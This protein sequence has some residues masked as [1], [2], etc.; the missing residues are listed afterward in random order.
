MNLG[1]PISVPFADLGSVNAPYRDELIQAF[2]KNLDSGWYI[3]G[4]QLKQF[5]S[6]F[7]AYVGVRDCVGVANGLDALSLVIRGWKEMG[8]LHEGDNVLVPANTYIA[9]ILA[10]TENNLVP[11][12]VEP[13]PVTFNI[14]PELLEKALNSKVR[15]VLAVHLY[16]QTANMSKIK[17]FSRDNGLI[18][19]EDAAQAHG[20]GHE[21]A[22]AGALGDASGFSFY[23]GKN[24]GALGDAGAITTN[25]EELTR[26]L[27]ALRNYGSE[28]KYHNQFRGVNSRLDEVQAAFLRVKL[29]YLNSENEKRRA[30]SS[31]YSKHIQNQLISLPRVPSEKLEH[32]WHAFVIRCSNRALL[33]AHLEGLGIQTLVHYP[34]PPHKQPAYSQL[35]WANVS[36]PIT[37]QIHREVLSL[38]ISPTMSHIEVDS[39]VKAVNSFGT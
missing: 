20:A 32:V 30:I 8:L 10:I 18:V 4:E 25:D 2:T 27:R 6:E 28:E 19:L 13:D 16:G 37:E 22:K 15:M 36:L 14:D 7:A 24:L 21:G 33:Q 35:T 3:L 31:H 12:L 34:I 38:P 39:V 11:V 23:P 29:P 5:E 26:I 9:S 17:R 1:K